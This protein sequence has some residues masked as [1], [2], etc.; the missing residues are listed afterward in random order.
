MKK[1]VSLTKEVRSRRHERLFQLAA[2]YRYGN[3]FG[4]IALPMGRTFCHCHLS[5]CSPGEADGNG[6]LSFPTD[7]SGRKKAASLD[8]QSFWHCRLFP[9]IAA[10]LTTRLSFRQQTRLR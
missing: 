9:P 3:C 5:P 4:G 7:D 6:I 8:H 2:V 1:Q 10:I